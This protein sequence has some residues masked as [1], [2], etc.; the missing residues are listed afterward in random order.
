MKPSKVI[1]G[2]VYFFVGGLPILVLEYVAWITNHR[3]FEGGVSAGILATL[4]C[5]VVYYGFFVLMQGFLSRWCK[6]ILE[7]QHFLPAALTSGI[8]ISFVLARKLDFLF[9]TLDGKEGD[10]IFASALVLEMLFLV[11][12][13]G[14]MWRVANAQKVNFRLISRIIVLLAATVALILIGLPPFFE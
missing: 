3:I 4:I 11:M 9:W 7:P 5:S 8:L 6:L 2:C 10:T 13:C 12:N 1:E 14:I